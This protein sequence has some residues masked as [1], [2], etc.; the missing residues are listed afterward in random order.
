MVLSKTQLKIKNFLNLPAVCNDFQ[1]VLFHC[2][3][4]LPVPNRILAYQNTVSGA[5]FSV[6]LLWTALGDRKNHETG[7]WV[8][9]CVCVWFFQLLFLG[10]KKIRK[11][12]QGTQTP[13]GLPKQLTLAEQ[14]LGGFL[15]LGGCCHLFKL[16]CPSGAL[17]LPCMLRGLKARCCCPTHSPASWL[18]PQLHTILQEGVLHAP[19]AAGCRGKHGSMEPIPQGEREPPAPGWIALIF[20]G[21]LLWYAIGNEDRNNRLLSAKSTVTCFKLI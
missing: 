19:H 12:Q 11:I 1:V 7:D 20:K 10:L 4:F 9:F 6:Y 14:C 13:A 15:S 2:P 3:R 16:L 8:F 18:V 17:Q 21:F 5:T